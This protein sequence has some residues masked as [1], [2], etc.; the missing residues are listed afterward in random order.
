METKEININVTGETKEIIIRHG[1]AIP[2]PEPEKMIHHGTIDAPFLFAENRSPEKKNSVISYSVEEK[3]IM[4]NEDIHNPL[5]P[6]VSGL[7]QLN[8]KLLQFKINTGDLWDLKDFSKFIRL[9]STMF[10]NR[11]AALDLSSKFSN[12]R[13][14]VSTVLEGNANHRTG[15]FRKLIEKSVENGLPESFKLNC[16]LFHGKPIDKSKFNVEVCIDATDSSIRIWLESPEL[17]ELEEELSAQL[18]GEQ[19]EKFKAAEFCCIKYR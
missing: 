5:A 16:D 2:M 18:I 17:I 9:N 13:A 6:H 4:Y 14:K 1:D 3:A 8:K 10:E 11:E 7:I 12:F 19:I 15:D